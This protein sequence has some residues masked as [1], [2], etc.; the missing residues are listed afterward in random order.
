MQ[1][2]NCAISIPGRA[3][4]GVI[5]SLKGGLDEAVFSLV[6]SFHADVVSLLKAPGPEGG[7]DAAALQERL[8]QR[9]PD[10]VAAAKGN[11]KPHSQVQH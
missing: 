10:L 7:A 3:L 9:L 1:V 2:H 5:D 8:Q 4:N 6:S 11:Q